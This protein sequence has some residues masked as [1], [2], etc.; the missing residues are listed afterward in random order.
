MNKTLHN[1]TW[2]RLH[3]G[4]VAHALT[5]LFLGTVCGDGREMAEY[6]DNPK[7][8][9]LHCE[10]KLQKLIKYYEHGILAVLDA[11]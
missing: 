8:R 1:P 5:N 11:E 10:A 7:K 9:C 6:V 4:R 2:I 3:R